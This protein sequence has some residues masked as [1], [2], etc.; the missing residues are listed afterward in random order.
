M[1][2]TNIVQ[3]SLKSYKENNKIILKG[4]KKIV[5]EIEKSIVT[6]KLVSNGL[7]KIPAR[8]HRCNFFVYCIHR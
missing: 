5:K 7:S 2:T 1:T 8:Y 6:L 4:N 3:M